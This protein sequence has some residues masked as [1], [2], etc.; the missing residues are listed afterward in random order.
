M[1]KKRKNKKP[2]A[3]E[4]AATVEKPTADIDSEGEEIENSMQDFFNTKEKTPNDVSIN[5]T[6]GFMAYTVS[7]SIENS[8]IDEEYTGNITIDDFDK[9]YQ[10]D[11]TDQKG[12][13]C[14]KGGNWDHE[15]LFDHMGR[16]HDLFHGEFNLE[17][18]KKNI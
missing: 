3:S 18:W 7:M 16:V 9:M 12:P 14:Q 13:I 8:S 11:D 10:E 6:Y 15:V 1:I 5:N 17:H 2:E 4:A